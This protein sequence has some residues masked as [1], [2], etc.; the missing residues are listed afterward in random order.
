MGSKK[1][2]TI[3]YVYDF[4]I[5]REVAV[6][7]HDGRKYHSHFSLKGGNKQP[8]FSNPKEVCKVCKYNGTKKCPKER[9]K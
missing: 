5:D 6:T 4:C 8:T 7:Y 3:L 9:K 1:E 2:E